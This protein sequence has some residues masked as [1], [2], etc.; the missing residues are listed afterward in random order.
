MNTFPLRIILLISYLILTQFG[1]AYAGNFGM[2][3][4]GG[5]GV[6]KYDERTSAL[7]NAL[8]SDS[9]QNVLLLGVSGEYTFPNVSNFYTG[10]TT[11]W[12]LGLKDEEVWKENGLELQTND[13]R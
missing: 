3:L 2:G 8:E 5:Y 7:G 6:L 10:I 13:M 1:L 4:H 12:A 9:S 11:D